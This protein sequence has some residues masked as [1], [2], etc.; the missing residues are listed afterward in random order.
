[1]MMQMLNGRNAKPALSGLK[2]ITF[3][4][5]RLRKK[6]IANMAAGSSIMATK[7]AARVRFMKTRNGSSG[8]STRDSTTKNST[9]MTAAA[10]RLAIVHWLP[11]P[12]VHVAGAGQA[13]DQGEQA[14]GA[15]DGARDVEL[16]RAGLGLLEEPRRQQSGDQADR[17]VDQEGQAPAVVGVEHAHVEPGQPATEDQADGRTGAGHRGVH[18]ERTGTRR[19][20]RERGGDQRQGGRRGER[21]AETLQAPGAQQQDLA[22]GETTEQRGDGEDGQAGHEDL[23]AAVEVAQSAA[24]EQQ[25]AE[26]EG[27]AGDDPGEVRAGHVEVSAD[28]GQSD[29]RDRG[30]EHHHELG[31]ADQHQGPTQVLLLTVALGDLGL[32]SLDGV[33]QFGHVFPYVV[34]LGTSYFLTVLRPAA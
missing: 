8:C 32:C 25:A 22:L 7:L 33:G 1:M 13:V 21:R 31:D 10:T 5:N 20:G 11:Q 6:N 15:E 34:G 4:M 3:W 16:A 23:A 17:H 14:A 9:S 26:G 30:V 24:E 12:Y 19:A 2:P 27:V 28:V 29:V 18:R